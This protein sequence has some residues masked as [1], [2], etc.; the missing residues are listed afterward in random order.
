MKK[1]WLVVSFIFVFAMAATAQR[2]AIV[3]TKY[4]LEKIPDYQE[5]QKKLD[6]FSVQWQKEIDTKQTELDTQKEIRT[7][8]WKYRIG[9]GRIPGQGDL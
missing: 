5:A 3:D 6:E 2:Y 1:I 8:C 4:I 9:T 7:A